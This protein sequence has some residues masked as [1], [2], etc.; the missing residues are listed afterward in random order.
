MKKKYLSGIMTAFIFFLALNATEPGKAVTST[1]YV[2]E[3]NV[4]PG[5]ESI[6]LDWVIPDEDDFL[7]YKI[8]GG[9]SPSN[10]E[11]LATITEKTTTT[12]TDTDVTP[13]VE[14]FY[15]VTY[16][17][18][19]FHIW[20]GSPWS[21]ST[22]PGIILVGPVVS[23]I[24]NDEGYLISWSGPN[25]DPNYPIENYEIFIGTNTDSM[26]LAGTTNGPTS[27]FQL[28]GLSSGSS[29][30]IK[31]RATNE[32]GDGEFSAIMTLNTPG[33][34]TSDMIFGIIGGLAAVGAAVTFFMT[35]KRR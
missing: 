20:G 22:I 32:I 27:Q 19:G 2:S 3:C 31:V 18:T 21:N 7:N 12:W 16:D 9:S 8:Y 10:Q 5:F 15:N 23:Y 30:K 28:T 13:S 29:Y 4:Y 1:N 11:L 6:T 25:D 14:R 34:T 26:I 17:F 24:E 33:T 35:E